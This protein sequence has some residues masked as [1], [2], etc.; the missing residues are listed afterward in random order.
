MS[1]ATARARQKAKAADDAVRPARQISYTP[2]LFADFYLKDSAGTAAGLQEAQDAV[3]S[4]IKHTLKHRTIRR[5]K[6]QRDP[7]VAERL[8]QTRIDD[9]L[10]A[11]D[12]A[13][14]PR[15]TWTVRLYYRST[16]GEI[17][18]AEFGGLSWQRAKAIESEH[19]ARQSQRDALPE[20]LCLF[21]WG[22]KRAKVD[23][24]GKLTLAQATYRST[25]VDF[26]A[27]GVPGGAIDAQAWNA[28]PGPLD[29]ATG[30]SADPT[31]P[32]EPESE[33]PPVVLYAARLVT[34]PSEADR[35]EREALAAASAMQ[36]AA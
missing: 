14:G 31:D 29:E 28:K 3:D 5:R 16:G 35:L 12:E 22:L 26:A 32:D 21:F 17:L 15:S 9:W 36:E 11:Q 33:G 30:T 25:A 10:E 7:A 4:Q 2:R 18:A 13:P 20:A 6:Q 27:L 34:F 8:R 19:K 1:N 23:K 24:R